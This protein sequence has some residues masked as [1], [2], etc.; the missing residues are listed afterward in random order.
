MKT[1]FLWTN[2]DIAR[3]CAINM[4]KQLEFLRRWNLKGT[5]CVVPCLDRVPII[6]DP[7][8]VDTLKQAESEGHELVQ[9][10]TT[11]ICEEN[12]LM[13]IRMLDFFP[14]KERWAYAKNRFVFET[15]WTKEAI[16]DQI[17]WGMK[18]WTEAFGKPSSGYRPG[19]GSFCSGMYE[20]LE[21]LGFKWCSGRLST[22]TSWQWNHGEY[23]YP[24]EVEPPIRPYWVGKVLEIPIY[25]EIAFRVPPQKVT[26][27][28]E[29]GKRNWERCVEN[30]WPYVLC[31]HYHGLEWCGGTGYQIHEEVIP[32][33]LESGQAEP[34][35]LT[36]YYSRVTGGE[37]PLAPEAELPPGPNEIPEWHVWSK[38]ERRR[39]APRSPTPRE[40]TSHT[41]MG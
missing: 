31:S 13:D 8:I 23:D 22:F 25:D 16:R 34:M 32:Y 2:D 5:F 28:I 24:E 19:C 9:H 38:R 15:L 10:G 26:D 37:Y 40:Q 4:H 11:H 12:G 1:P 3:G 21:E 41:N 27:F 36:Q 6:E 7:E 18:V 14:A 33:I 39:H 20:A 35:T 30:N 17:Q 29:L